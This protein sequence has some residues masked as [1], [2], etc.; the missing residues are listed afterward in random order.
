[1]VH[2]QTVYTVNAKTNEV[3]SWKYS[4]EIPTKDGLLVHL[5]AD[6]NQCFLPRRCVFETELEAKIIANAK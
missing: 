5:R 2:G 6:N 4:G 3:D 1:M